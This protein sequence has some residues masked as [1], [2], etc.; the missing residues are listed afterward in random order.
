VMLVVNYVVVAPFP[1]VGSLEHASLLPAAPCR[2]LPEIL[3][4]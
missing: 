2:R 4:R 1:D 3:P